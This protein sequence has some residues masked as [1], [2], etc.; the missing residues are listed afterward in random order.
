MFK[1]TLKNANRLDIEMSGMLDAVAMNNAL[2]EL[3]LKSQNIRHGKMLFDV[4]DFHLPTIEA[5]IIEFSRFPSMYDFLGKFDR[6]VVLTDKNWLKKAGELEGALIP[7]IKI[8][9]F[10]REHRAE[11]EAWLSEK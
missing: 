10:G 4:V 9:A 1:V 3:S 5:I 8:R 2:D 7:G 6:A 11:A